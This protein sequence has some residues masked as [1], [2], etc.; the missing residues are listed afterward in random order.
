STGAQNRNGKTLKPRMPLREAPMTSARVALAGACPRA[1]C[2]L[3]LQRPGKPS[4]KKGRQ[5]P[6]QET[7]IKW[8]LDNSEKKHVEKG[9]IIP[10]TKAHTHAYCHLCPREHRRQRPRPREPAARATRLV[11]HCRPHRRARIHRPRI[12]PERYQGPQAVRPAV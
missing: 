8:A 4:W 3:P 1:E 12:R 9:S 5:N 10:L 7:R 2:A 6:D 11:R